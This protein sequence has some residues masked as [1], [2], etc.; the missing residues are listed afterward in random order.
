M[1]FGQEDDSLVER[2]F[3]VCLQVDYEGYLF[4]YQNG[5]G[6]SMIK[7]KKPHGP[8]RRDDG[9]RRH[10]LPALDERKSTT[11]D[12]RRST[13]TGELRDCT[14]EAHCTASHGTLKNGLGATLKLV[15]GPT[16]ADEIP[17]KINLLSHTPSD[18]HTLAAEQPR[19][20]PP[21]SPA[22]LLPPSRPA[23][24]SPPTPLPPPQ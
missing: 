12:L 22:G 11:Q 5:G 17:T 21:Y 6:T 8:S 9:S 23:H 24:T 3:T 16:A 14:G 15:R 4:H 10:L 2:T 19:S 13:A 18:R 1:G 20:T 7:I